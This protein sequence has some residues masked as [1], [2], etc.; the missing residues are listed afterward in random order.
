MMR[1]QA[2]LKL[3]ADAEQV[4]LDE[5]TALH[6]AC[7]T[8]DPQLKLQL[9]QTLIQHGAGK[10]INKAGF[11][12]STPLL[13]CINNGGL[14]PIRFLLKS[15]ADPNNAGKTKTLPLHRASAG[16]DEEMVRLLLESGANPDALDGNQLSALA[17]AAQT[18]RTEIVKIL[19]A[20][21]AK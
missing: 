19:L 4:A 17:V 5:D 8:N 12:G 18:G 13:R 9:L 10:V 3:G 14:E 2:L 20:H 16:E 15:G 7:Q 1:V 11:K 21:T 6:L